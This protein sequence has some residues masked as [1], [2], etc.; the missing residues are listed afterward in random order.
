MLTDCLESVTW[1]I[2]GH[3]CRC[4]Q[5]G[6][7]RAASCMNSGQTCHQLSINSWIKTMSKGSPTIKK[8]S[9]HLGIAQIAIRPPPHS[10]GHSVA[11]IF[12]QNHANAH[13]YMDISPKNRCHKPSWQGF[14]PPHPNGQC[15]N[16]Q[17][18]FLRWG[19]P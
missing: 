11:P 10:N 9:V 5:Q 17:R 18:F 4:R 1:S 16:E 7:Q 12:G 15:P 6:E 8:I 3:E 13:L 19:F 2:R 14:R